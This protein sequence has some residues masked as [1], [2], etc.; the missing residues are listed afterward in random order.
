MRRVMFVPVGQPAVNQEY[1]SLYPGD[2]ITVIEVS[3]PLTP[4]FLVDAIR[5]RPP[6]HGMDVL[7]VIDV[8]V[9]SLLAHLEELRELDQFLSPRGTLFE[10][11]RT[12]C[13]ASH[14]YLKRVLQH[15]CPRVSDINASTLNQH[16]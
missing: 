1:A 6:A 16:S 7:M 12:N 2:A 13:R 5:R 10:F 4:A 3:G 14:A 11:V 9:D 15:F 8:P